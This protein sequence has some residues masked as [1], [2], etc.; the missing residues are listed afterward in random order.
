MK[1]YVLMKAVDLGS[2]VVN[3]YRNQDKAL[4]VRDELNG[5]KEYGDFWGP[6]YFVIEHEVIE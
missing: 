3:V 1:V 4:S 5:T 2:N 6:P